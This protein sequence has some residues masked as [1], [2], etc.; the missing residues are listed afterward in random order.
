[1]LLE[2]LA[3]V[4]LMDKKRASVGSRNL[5][6]RSAIK[7]LLLIDTGGIPLAACVSAANQNCSELLAPILVR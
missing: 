4:Q 3:Q 6:C 7:H 5:L 2:R 1:M